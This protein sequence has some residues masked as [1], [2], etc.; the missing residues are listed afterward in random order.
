MF[1]CP[2]WHLQ[3]RDFLSQNTPLHHRQTQ[4]VAPCKLFKFANMLCMVCL[5]IKAVR[6]RADVPRGTKLYAAST[7][8][9]LSRR[10]TRCQ[11]RLQF[12][13]KIDQ[14]R[15]TAAD[16]ASLPVRVAA[17]VIAAVTSPLLC[18]QHVVTIAVASCCCLRP[19]APPTVAA[20]PTAC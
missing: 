18:P 10:F 19:A 8:R 6:Q 3:R 11:S 16:T 4:H 12:S 20:A 7:N 14:G 2:S 17:L 15:K 9:D 1:L 13:V 5:C